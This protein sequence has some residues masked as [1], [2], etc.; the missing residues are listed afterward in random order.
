MND[1]KA[2]CID[3]GSENCPCYLALTNDCLTCS[4]LQGKDCQ[5]CDWQGVCIYNEFM[6]GNQKVLNP[7]KDFEAKVLEI[8]TYEDDLMVMVVQVGRGFALKCSRPGIFVF[9]GNEQMSEYHRTPISVLKSDVTKG[10]LHLAV[11]IISAKTKSLVELEKV[12]IRGPYK[13]GL[14][15][16]L[17]PTKRVLALSK[18]IGIAP[19]IHYAHC[20]S[21][22]C[23]VDFIVDTEKISEELVNFYLENE[24]SDGAVGNIDY[25]SFGDE[26]GIGKIE[27]KLVEGGYETVLI[28]A[29]DYFI[30]TLS[31]RVKELCPGMNVVISNNVNMCCGEGVCGACTY[32]DE[33]GE[34]IKRCKC[35][36]SL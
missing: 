3:A 33:N 34:V 12:I 22:D 13:T 4:R 16:D 8:K 21:K 30:Q 7:R 9:M 27:S 26:G 18:G 24:K 19:G 5:Q 1:K 14:V 35:K 11:K 28:L 15:G 25:I 6:Q 29:S 23:V 2:R 31:K 10:T 20:Q 36:F 32:V 17:T